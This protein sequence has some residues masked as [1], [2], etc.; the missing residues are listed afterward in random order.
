DHAQPIEQL[1]RGGKIDGRTREIDD[2]LRR[3]E[4]GHRDALP[5]QAQ[6]DQEADRPGSDDDDVPLAHHGDPLWYRAVFWADSGSTQICPSPVPL[7]ICS[8]YVLIEIWLQSRAA[9]P[10]QTAN[11]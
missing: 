3:I 10:P 2:A 6:R 5:R 4:Q 1:Q 8:L 9:V 7:S 11:R